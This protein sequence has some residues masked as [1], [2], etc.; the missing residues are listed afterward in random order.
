MHSKLD[1]LTKKATPP[2][3]FRIEKHYKSTK[4]AQ[5]LTY[6]CRKNMQLFYSSRILDEMRFY[7]ELWF[8]Q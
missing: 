7:Q 6:F 8:I 4:S 5:F 3:T 2:P 1:E